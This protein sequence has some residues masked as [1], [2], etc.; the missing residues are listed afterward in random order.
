MVLPVVMYR[1]E[2]W[3]IRKAE[4]WKIDAFKLWCWRRHLRVLWTE[5][6]SNQSILK[7]INPGYSLEG[8]MLK[9]QYFGYLKWRADSLEETLMLGKIAGRRRRDD[10]GWDSWM[11]HRLNRHESEQ[12]QGDS[13]GQ[14]SLASSSPWGCKETDMTVTEWVENKSKERALRIICIQLKCEFHWEN[15]SE[16]SKRNIFIFY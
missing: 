10:R 2:S 9:L 8:P 15:L 13:E 7:K 12:T 1:C 14:G 5:R 6:R 3:T 11:H 4:H 16:K